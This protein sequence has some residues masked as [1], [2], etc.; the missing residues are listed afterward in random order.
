MKVTQKQKSTRSSQAPKVSTVTGLVALL[1]LA[2]AY[3]QETRSVIF[4]RV[5]DLQSSIIAGATVT[6]F[7]ADTGVSLSLTTNETGYYEAPLLL[8]GNYRVSAEMSGY[9]KAIRSGIALPVST[10]VEINLQL[11]LGPVN[12]S[13]SVT[14][15][16][17]LL[18]SSSVTSGRILDN[19]NLMDLPYFNNSPALLV[20]ITPGVQSSGVR[21]YNG[22]NALGGVSDHRVAGGVG[23]SEYSIDGAPNAGSG[24]QAAY[25]PY[26]DTIQEV[27][28]ETSNFD[29]AFGHSTGAS[30][31]VMTK[32]GTNAYHGTMTWQHWQQRWNAARFF[33]NTLRNRQIAAAQA[34][35]DQALVDS[36]RAQPGQPSG[37]SN[38]YAATVGGP[39]VIPKLYDGRNRLFFFFS[40]DGFKDKKPAEFE[41]NRTI[42][43]PAQLQGD[44][45]DLLKVD[46]VRY[47]LY[48]PLSVRPDPA[49]PGHYIRDPFPGNIIPR[50]RIINPAYEH[51]INF[52]PRPNNNPADPRLEPTNNYLAVGMPF[53]WTYHALANR[54]DYV[55]SE[56]H[57]FFARWNKLKYRE[58]R[59]DWTYESAR[60]LHKDGVN[61]DNLSGT[62]DWVY[63]HSSRTVFDFV[64]AASDFRTGPLFELPFTFRPSDVGLPAYLNDKAGEQ[65]VLP[66]MSFEG[67]ETIGQNVP[68]FTHFQ[69]ISGKTIVSHV[70][71]NHSLRGGFEMRQFYR[72]G[73]GGGNT[74]GNFGFSNAFTRKDDDGFTPA[75]DLG[76]SWAAFMLGLPDSL[77]IETNDN[78]ATHNPY[79][80]WF[81]QDQW[82]VTSKLT[83]TPG[84]RL[85]YELGATER[86]NRVIGYLDPDAKLPISDVSQAAYAQSPI[87]ELAA[88]DFL[89]KGGSLYPGTDGLSR[90]LTNNE[91]MWLPRFGMAYQLNTKTVIRGGYG[92]FFDT[93]NALNHTINTDNQW[94]DQTGFSR[95]TSSIV[96]DDFGANWLLGDP[97]NGVSPLANP[98][99]LRSDGTRFDAPQRDALG[100]MARAGREWAFIDFNARRA[101]QQRWRIG[102]Q[103][104][105][106]SN[107]VVEVAYAG[108][109]SDRVPLDKRL[110]FLPEQYWADGLVRDNA[111]ANNLNSNVPNPFQL[112]NFS[113]L[114]STHP[115]IYQELSRVGRFTSPTIRKH[116]L[117]RAF[118][119]FNDLTQAR[120]PLGKVRTDALEV[121][122]DRRFARGFT[123]IVNYTKLRNDTADFFLNEYDEQPT[124]RESDLG[125]PHRVSGS[126]IVELPFGKGRRWG[127]SGIWNA[128]FGGIQ[129]A[130]TYEWQPG[131]LLDW[132]NLF[133]YGDPKEIRTN[134]RNLEQWFTTD[135][136]ER[137]SSRAPAEFHRTVFPT[138]IDDVRADSLNRWDTNLQRKF[139]LRENLT[140]ELRLDALNL[141]NR[142][143]FSAPVTDPLSTDFGK[144]VA[145]ESSTKRFFQIQ[146]RIRF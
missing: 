41:I 107:M 69:V 109:Y 144:V 33:T 40:L 133:Y 98:F 50:N 45:S 99:P 8:P 18:D 37:H 11:E 81:I 44:F 46:P 60:G 15:E 105:L 49:R 130:A 132:P 20:K 64:F 14:A 53:D 77:T 106:G 115:T 71:G 82:R 34:A 31:S 36:L 5:L 32:A 35:G 57:R 128:L 88:S 75:G 85:E 89:V 102:A 104:Q 22:V 141:F 1:L 92:V 91:L 59:F 54:I 56:R 136:F 26:S 51:Y 48:D 116:Q 27:K 76:H 129:I 138:R 66:L 145:E 28:I 125:R 6:V 16:P 39:V 80:A 65:H 108:S 67:Y 62:A 118:P 120:M 21:R 10:R 2:P 101:R 23:G 61:R 12:E 95:A 86:F 42:P 113:G 137:N 7:N 72:L 135:N 19:R 84:L 117:L 47:Q 13:V 52:L 83:L 134:G 96:T 110:D 119:H 58:D 74:S 124:W 3:A 87:P 126:G 17:P 90:R 24:Y 143:Q 68:T 79:Y 122:F 94:P 140:F 9:K 131:P 103:R 73:G 55:H 139:K 100:L 43:T 121:T 78:Y 112:S 123:L 70:R 114:Q 29:A 30:I 142:S 127:Q 38:N 63:T 93:I 111:I 4:G 25:L 146:M 97:R